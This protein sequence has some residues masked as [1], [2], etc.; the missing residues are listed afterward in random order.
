MV[1]F[2]KGRQTSINLNPFNLSVR[3][4]LALLNARQVFSAGHPTIHFPFTNLFLEYSS[5]TR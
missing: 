4:L 1:T 5:S 2:I 3:F